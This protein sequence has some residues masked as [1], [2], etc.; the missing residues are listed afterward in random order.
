MIASPDEELLER[1]LVAFGNPVPREPA[2]LQ[3]RGTYRQRGAHE[4][5]GRES[6]P[7]MRSVGRRVWPT[8]HPDGSFP[9]ERLAEPVNGDQL[10]RVRVAFLPRPRVAER[11]HL[12]RGDIAIALMMAQREPRRIV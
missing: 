11:A 3:V 8:V 1:R 6:H 7:G 12:I 9:F 5:A 10:V 4:T 2:L